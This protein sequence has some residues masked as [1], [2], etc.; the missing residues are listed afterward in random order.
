MKDRVTVSL[1][2]DLVAELRR[3]AEADG[4]SFSAA[5]EQVL[6]DRMKRDAALARWD[7]AYGPPDSDGLAWAERVCGITRSQDSA[8]RAS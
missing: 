8:A 2:P 1:D 3:R 5:L 4:V 7:A 6:A